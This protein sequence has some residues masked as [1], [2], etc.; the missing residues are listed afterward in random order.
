MRVIHL[1]GAAS[2]TDPG[3]ST[4]Y[5]AGPDGVFDLPEHVGAHY[6]TKHAGMFRRESDHEAL[7]AAKKA[8]QLANPHNTA[9]TLKALLERVTALEGKV[10][11]WEKFF[12]SDMPPAPP[13]AAPEHSGA[14]ADEAPAEESDSSLDEAKALLEKSNRAATEQRNQDADTEDE[15]EPEEDG[16]LRKPTPRKT[17][18]KRRG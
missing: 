10:A 2:F 15:A 11:A 17:A 13:A 3:T 5:E 7:I 18:A 9:P 16:A 12:G 8:E 14:A 1:M 6:T 4:T